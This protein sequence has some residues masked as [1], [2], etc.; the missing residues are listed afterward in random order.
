MKYETYR[1]R[2]ARGSRTV[3]ATAVLLGLGLAQA[4]AAA[5]EGDALASDDVGAE[6]AVEAQRERRAE[7]DAIIVTAARREQNLLDVPVAVTAFGNEELTE[8]GYRRLNDLKGMA[9][10]VHA[11]DAS[12]ATQGIFIRGF[13]T[14]VQ[15]ANAAVG[16]YLDDV[17][18]PR[19]YGTGWYG[20][21]PDIERIEVLRG[22]QGTLYGQNTSAGA[23]KLVSRTPSEEFRAFGEL[24][25][26]SRSLREVRAYVSGALTENTA[27]SIA[28]ASLRQDGADTNVTL[29]R[30]VGRYNNDQIRFITQSRLGDRLSVRFSADYLD[31]SSDYRTTSPQNIANPAPR[32]TY[33][34]IDPAFTFRIGGASLTAEYAIDDASQLRSITAYRYADNSLPVD[35]DALPTYTS[36]FIQDLNQNQ[37]SQEFQ[38]LLTS[39]RWDLT[40]GLIGFRESFRVD[41]INWTNDNFTGLRSE[42]SFESVGI[43]GQTDYRLNDATS[44]VFGLR[45][46][47]EKRHLDYADGYNSNVDWE[48]LGNR[49]HVEDLSRSYTSVSPRIGISH[50]LNDSN[51]VY[52]TLS[53]GTTSGGF[54]GAPGNAAVA[55]ISTDQSTATTYEAGLKSQFLDNRVLL[56]V[57]AYRNE[58]DDYQASITNPVFDGVQIT[59]NVIQNAGDASSYG[60]DIEARAQI[61]PRFDAALAVGLLRSEFDSYV[62]PSGASTSDYVGQ[63]LP[64]AP[65]LAASLR[66]G[67]TLDFANGGSLRLH[68]SVRH[69]DEYYTAITPT[70]EYTKYPTTTY[71]DGGVTY[72]TPSGQ[73]RF[74]LDGHNL[75][76]RDYILPSFNDASFTYN[77]P[78]SVQ[79]RVSYDY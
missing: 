49:F 21:L 56:T 68:G 11:P 9:A 30:D 5:T 62:N 41:R 64:N 14:S 54:N 61:T 59:G 58:Y 36:G 78:R 51:N 27:A 22:P 2:S 39:G 72:T 66:L 71:V 44:F 50:K 32:T 7:L 60:L 65:E 26:G 1:P 77:K 33:S 25:V 47:Y 69:L 76:D 29:G 37:L 40:A 75:Q 34:D 79:F 63:A 23:V 55:R 12:E 20:S 35:S 48:Y 13:G 43:Y 18:L 45:A 16:F 70:R 6:G 73:W 52:V 10:G 3:L 31:D 53:R 74:T 8:R 28:V 4:H 24:S 67:Y 57:A 15:M 46:G 42:T 38:Y 19:P 17:Y